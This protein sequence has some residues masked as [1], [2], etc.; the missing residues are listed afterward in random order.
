MSNPTDIDNILKKISNDRLEGDE[1]IKKEIEIEKKNREKNDESIFQQILIESEKRRNKT[2]ELEKKLDNLIIADKDRRENM[3]KQITDLENKIANKQIRRVSLLKGKN[4]IKISN[5]NYN[6]IIEKVL[7]NNKVKTLYYDENMNII[8]DKYYKNLLAKKQSEFYKYGKIHPRLGKKLDEMKD[9]EIIEINIYKSNKDINKFD[10]DSKVEF[11]EKFRNFQR[12]N[13]HINRPGFDNFNLIC[14]QF[15]KTSEGQEINKRLM[16]SNNHLE[17][18]STKL[19]KQSILK[20]K[21]NDN[22]LGLF[23]PNNSFKL[24]ISNQKN[25]SNASVIVDTEGWRGTNLRAC[26]FEGS[27]G[28]DD[29]LTGFNQINNNIDSDGQ[30]SGIQEVYKNSTFPGGK[31]SDHATTVTAIITNRAPIVNQRGFAP[32]S[33]IYCANNYSNKSLTWAV[34]DKHCRV[35]NQSFHRDNEWDSPNQEEDDIY[36]DYLALNFPYPFITSASGNWS[37]SSEDEPGGVDGSLEF[38]NHKCYN[39]VTVGNAK[40][41]VSNSPDGMRPS[42]VWKNPDSD[43]GDWEFP[44]ICANGTEVSYNGED[45]GSG[46]SFS[47]PAVAGTA[48][49]IQNADNDLLNWPEGV[50]AILLAG[51]IHNIRDSS[52]FSDVLNNNDGYDG[53]GAMDTKESMRIT[54]KTLTS[55]RVYMNN[56]P[57]PRGWSIGTLKNSNF[58]GSKDYISYFIG[59]PNLSS[60]GSTKSKI[61]VALT[62]DS[63]IASI[64]GIPLMSKLTTDHDLYLYNQS[65]SLVAYSISWDNSYEIIDFEGKRG[66]VY[67]IRIKRHSGSDSTWFGLA[68]TAGDGAY[69]KLT[70]EIAGID[71]NNHALNNIF[72]NS[73]INTTVGVNFEGLNLENLFENSV[74]NSNYIIDV[75]NIFELNTELEQ[76]VTIKINRSHLDKYLRDSK[77]E[78]LLMKLNKKN[79]NWEIVNSKLKEDCFKVYLERNDIYTFAIEDKFNSNGFSVLVNNMWKMVPNLYN[80]KAIPITKNIPPS[81]IVVEYQN[82]KV[83]YFLTENKNINCC[84]QYN[85]HKYIP[86]DKK[87]LRYSPDGV[88]A[89]DYITCRVTLTGTDNIQI[90]I[91]K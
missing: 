35:V 16:A 63:K 82:C 80:V 85:G 69:Y 23:L 42:S 52:W 66:E 56:K 47:S 21:N 83:N 58:T 90:S 6:F 62:W 20:I 26:V 41:F 4:S 9:D 1:K 43:H 24:D 40:D 76:N 31:D 53:C 87:L 75:E 84:F 78:I 46:T 22:I 2:L 11:T 77:K 57:K 19:S 39:C 28:N 64:F 17:I 32:D 8:S 38:V 72:G 44:E 51:A 65:G 55:G 12:K 67:E 79:L 60:D 49:L 15:L 34:Q 7:E 73:L 3:K 14:T 10:Y 37:S 86:E 54:R 88:V 61:R 74:T 48:L 30:R 27:P 36:K 68:W 18:E 13:R 59:V 33:L 70:K 25:D 29:G 71:F 91:E 50:K 5:K 45:R 81:K 89:L